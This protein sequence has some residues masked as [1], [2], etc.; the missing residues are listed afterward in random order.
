MLQERWY[1]CGLSLTTLVTSSSQSEL[2]MDRKCR[3]RDFFRSRLY[4]LWWPATQL[5]TSLGGPG[6][7]GCGVLGSP[8]Y[9]PP[10]SLSTI[11]L[12]DLENMENMVS[13]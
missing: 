2:N 7:R 4:S 6:G 1:S 13:V 3:V 11:V 9:T 10:R 8:V 5:R 12:E